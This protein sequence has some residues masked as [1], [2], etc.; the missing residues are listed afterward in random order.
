MQYKYVFLLVASAV[1]SACSSTQSTKV[2]ESTPEL[3]N[4]LNKIRL[5]AALKI[6]GEKAFIEPYAPDID[7]VNHSWESTNY[8]TFNARTLY[9]AFDTSRQKCRINTPECDALIAA[10]EKSPF[11]NVNNFSNDYGDTYSERVAKGRE[12]GLTGSEMVIYGIGAPVMAVG[13]AAGVALASPLL[14]LTGAVSLATEGTV[15]P[16]KTVE[17]DHDSF[18]ALAVKTVQYEY[19][20][21]E[22]YI[23][24]LA[25]A[26]ALQKSLKNDLENIE[27]TVDDQVSPA[28]ILA[29]KMRIK[30]N[31][32]SPEC[33]Y[34]IPIKGDISGAKIDIINE[35]NTCLA[36]SAEKHIAKIQTLVE[37]QKSKFVAQQ[38]K[39]YDSI[40]H[41]DS[42]QA[43][44]DKYEHRDVAQ[45]VQLAQDKLDVIVS[46]E[47][48]RIT[49]DLEA[50][51]SALKVGDMTFCGRV[52]N[53][54]EGGMFRISLN[55]KLANY[56]NEIWL[57]SSE[58]FKPISGCYNRNGKVTPQH[59]P[60]DII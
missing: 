17:F 57:H 50:F 9:P 43:F 4:K 44:I 27:E 24:Q 11:L 47:R 54:R 28:R 52:I 14:A 26:S 60:Y 10:A 21:I 38:R 23:D 8:F 15:I 34:R 29:R 30:I 6:E 2:F 41:I 39:E 33:S 59:N 51:R 42:A 48:K 16:N 18:V 49:A 58:I 12:P 31:S 25:E 7:K 35:Y 20:S 19:G 53:K 45:L 56:E 22:N 36:M 46:V 13:A 1:L 5:V 55:A 3:E 40:Y 32:F 37:A